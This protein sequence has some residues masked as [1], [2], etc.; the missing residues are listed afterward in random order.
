[1]QYVKCL[2][3]F[4]LVPESDESSDDVSNELSDDKEDEKPDKISIYC[5]ALW[6]S[7]CSFVCYIA[8]LQLIIFRKLLFFIHI[9]VHFRLFISFFCFFL[10]FPNSLVFSPR[11]F[12]TLKIFLS[13]LSPPHC[14]IMTQYVF[15]SLLSLVYHARHSRSLWML[16]FVM[17]ILKSPFTIGFFLII[18]C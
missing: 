16:I 14:I 13:F 10:C 2:F 5:C 1:M 6:T 18:L 15:Q 11:F 3:S 9:S 4:F 7:S 8:A 12:L 17:V